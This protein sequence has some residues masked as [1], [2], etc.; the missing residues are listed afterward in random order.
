M[1]TINN[2]RQTLKRDAVQKIDEMLGQE[3]PK[4]GR[5]MKEKEPEE[6]K[7]IGRPR[8]FQSEQE[9]I[10]HQTTYNREFKREE[11]PYIQ[12]RFHDPKK[13]SN[14][15]PLQAIKILEDLYGVKFNVVPTSYEIIPQTLN[16]ESN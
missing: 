16:D 6:P 11:R 15:D 9:R 8:K 4:K 1:E 3:K 12:L 13:Y 2:L 5:P 7:A 10:Q 14:A